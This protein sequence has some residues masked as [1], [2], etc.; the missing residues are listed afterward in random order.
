MKSLFLRLNLKDFARGLI[1]AIGTVILTGLVPILE[2]GKVPDLISLK[3]ACTAGI[4]A[5][6]VYLGKNLVT[7]SDDQI[8]KIE[9]PTIVK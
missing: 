3:A 4:A 9:D 8:G 2:A 7:N 5:G 1:V 6:L